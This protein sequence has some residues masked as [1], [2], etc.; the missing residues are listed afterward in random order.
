[1]DASV[2]APRSPALM[3][4]MVCGLVASDAAASRSRSPHSLRAAPLPAAAPAPPPPAWW[5]ACTAAGQP[6]RA[7]GL[8]PGLTEAEGD[9]G[10]GRTP[11]RPPPPPLSPSVVLA[12]AFA[13]EADRVERERGRSD[14]AAAAAAVA[15]ADRR[16]WAGRGCSSSAE[17]QPAVRAA[18]TSAWVWVAAAVCSAIPVVGER[19]MARRAR[20]ARAAARTARVVV[21]GAGRA[22]AAAERRLPGMQTGAGGGKRA[23]EGRAKG[24]M[25]CDRQAGSAG[26]QG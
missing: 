8:S 11:K 6:L 22:G 18:S 7:L 3:L 10:P 21:G 4:A 13:R 26:K 1:M 25:G 2:I 17:G 20:A 24:Q 5:G 12:G 16:H 15:A 19:A 14:A 9:C 23:G